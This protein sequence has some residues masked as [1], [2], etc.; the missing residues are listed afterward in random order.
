MELETTRA[1][2][3]EPQQE[4]LEQRLS[5]AR[6]SVTEKSLPEPVRSDFEARSGYAAG[7]VRVVESDLPR[8]LGANAVTQGSTI[9][10]PRGGYAPDTAEGSR[11]LHHELGHTVQQAQG[12]VRPDGPAGLNESPA[13][14]HAADTA[15]AK[16]DYGAG[17]AAGSALSAMPSAGSGAPMQMDKKKKLTRA[18][19]QAMLDQYGPTDAEYQKGLGYFGRRRAKKE[20]AAEKK[21][22]E[23]MAFTDKV[24]ASQDAHAAHPSAATLALASPDEEGIGF[25]EKRRR[26]RALKAAQKQDRDTELHNR[27]LDMGVDFDSASGNEKRKMRKQIIAAER[28]I[29]KQDLASEMQGTRFAERMHSADGTLYDPKARRRIT[30]GAGGAG[31]YAGVQGSIAAQNAPD[32]GEVARS[33]AENSSKKISTVFGSTPSAVKGAKSAADSIHKVTGVDLPLSDQLDVAAEFMKSDTVKAVSGADSNF[34]GG[35]S[36]V[37]GG[38]GKAKEANAARRAGDTAAAWQS[39][40]GSAGAFIGAGGSF[41]DSASA[42]GFTPT[43]AV[44]GLG[45]VSGSLKTGGAIAQ[46]AGAAHTDRSMANMQKADRY[47]KGY[48][49]KSDADADRFEQMSMA[50]HAAQTREVTGGFGIASGLMQTGAG[51]ANVVPGGQGAAAVLKAGSTVA[52][53]GGTIAGKAMDRRFVDR[54]MSDAMG[55]TEMKDAVARAKGAGDLGE[56]DQERV[57]AKVSGI[58]GKN[59]RHQLANRMAARNAVNLHEKIGAGKL[60]PDD[61]TLLKGFGYSDPAKFKN[62]SVQML[63]NKMGIKGSW[64]DALK[65]TEQIEKDQAAAKDRALRLKLAKKNKA[66]A[67][68]DPGAATRREIARGLSEHPEHNHISNLAAEAARRRQK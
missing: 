14:E 52:D 36:S 7:G 56:K 58:S 61:V 15:A 19:E 44:P 31:S 54:T 51:I 1:L 3:P 23:K 55:A 30:P 43:E 34:F 32:L 38:I 50:R 48:D 12:R 45:I 37:M 46:V 11:V 66:A 57:L 25:W 40:I 59:K 21:H 18:E 24:R 62:I 42:M 68:K 28:R 60:D 47:A 8:A 10:F 26:A 16:P 9:H 29:K 2:R 39:G 5:R 4:T 67:D 20:A 22:D 53:V 64:E 13:L 17:H 6:G 65:D 49:S 63:A 41:Y 33:S 35:F 27:M